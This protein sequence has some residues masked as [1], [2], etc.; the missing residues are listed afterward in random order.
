MYFKS[1]TLAEN[2]ATLN[3][4]QIYSYFRGQNIMS[5]GRPTFLLCTNRRRERVSPQAFLDTTVSDAE[6]TGTRGLN[7]RVFVYIICK[8][9]QSASFPSELTVLEHSHGRLFF[10]YLTM[11]SSSSFGENV[12]MLKTASRK[13]LSAMGPRLFSLP[14]SLFVNGPFPRLGLQL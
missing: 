14:W 13:T 8:I 5:W 12:M 2:K 1:N 11:I 6:T 7:S 9:R 10:G 3:Q 4:T